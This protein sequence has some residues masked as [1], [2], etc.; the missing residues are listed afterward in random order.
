[1]VLAVELHD[2]EGGTVRLEAEVRTYRDLPMRDVGERSGA[3][4]V[5]GVLDGAPIEERA[6]PADRRVT[7]EFTCGIFGFALALLRRSRV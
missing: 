2:H 3:I 6:A 5:N 7:V 4:A 1:V